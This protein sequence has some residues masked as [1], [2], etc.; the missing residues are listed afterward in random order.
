M[1]VHSERA[2]DPSL[3]DLPDLPWGG[4]PCKM[5]SEKEQE[6]ESAIAVGLGKESDLD[7]EFR[8]GG[9]RQAMMELEFEMREECCE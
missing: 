6:L 7:W 1:A 2:D 4:W 5:Q 3:E 9:Q 8:M